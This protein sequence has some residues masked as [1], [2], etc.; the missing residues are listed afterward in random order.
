MTLGGSIRRRG[1]RAAVG[2]VVSAIVLSAGAMPA[3]ARIKVTVPPGSGLALV[4]DY[5]AVNGGYGRPADTGRTIRH[6]GIDFAARPGTPVISASFG[7][8]AW[9]QAN[10]CSGYD[11]V[12]K[13]TIRVPQG[14]RGRRAPIYAIYSHAK[15]LA[16]LSVGDRVRP[17]DELGRVIPLLGTPCYAS[18]PHVHF[19]LRVDNRRALHTNPH[20]FWA[21]GPGA[22]TC[23]RAGREVPADKIVAPLRCN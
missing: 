19:E 15:P 6:H 22:V 9:M 1:T 14:N 4:N 12:I 18:K 7:E 20:R 16:N 17:G 23:F 13:T 8:I 3:A 11:I 10:R 2:A 5:L 21:D